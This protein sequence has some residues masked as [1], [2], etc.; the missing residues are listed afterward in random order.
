[1]GSFSRLNL[2][3]SLSLSIPSPSESHLCLLHNRPSH[4]ELH[5]TAAAAT[6][7]AVV[8]AGGACLGRRESPAVTPWKPKGLVEQRVP[9]V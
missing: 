2:D 1:M 7:T 6:V 9:R 4:N 3:P 8:V 5:V